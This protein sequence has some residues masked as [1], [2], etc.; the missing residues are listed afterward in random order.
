MNYSFTA[1]GEIVKGDYAGD[2]DSV[3]DNGDGTWTAKGVVGKGGTDDYEF[4]GDVDSW[5]VECDTE[6]YTL[7][8]DGET[9][10]P[11]ELTGD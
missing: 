5:S 11:S 3:T 4:N 1:D 10:T 9:I 8:L 6:A 2:D 7:R